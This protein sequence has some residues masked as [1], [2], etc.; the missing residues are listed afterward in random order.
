MVT[1]E[2]DNMTNPFDG[3]RPTIILGAG[4]AGLTA[5]WELVEQGRPTMVVDLEDAPGG[6]C[7]TH[8]KD[9]YRFDLGGHRFISRD[10]SLTDM[11]AGL[12]GDDLLQASRQSMILLGGKR[13]RYPL[14]PLNMLQNLDPV[15]G[16]RGVLDYLKQRAWGETPAPGAEVSFRN[17]TEA[18]YGRTFYD[19]FFGPYTEKLWG[20]PAHTLSGDW[21]SQRISLLNLTDV[22]LRLLKVRGGSTRTYARKYHYPRKGIGQIFAAMTD[23]LRRRGA[24]VRLGTRVTGLELK[25]GEVARVELDGPL[26]SYSV[27]PEQVISTLPLPDLARMLR[28]DSPAVV[29]AADR[30]RFRAVRF[31]DMMLDRPDLSPNTWMYVPDPRCVFTRIQE[32]KRRSPES[33]PPGKTSVMLEIPCDV[34]DEIWS[35]TDADLMDRCLGE[36]KMLGFDV[37]RHVRGCMSQRI[38]HGSV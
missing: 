17:W 4:A 29:D 23:E 34:G 12:L 32:P 31:L 6:L 10:P 33:A 15:V 3:A 13:Y 21:A 30:L 35:Q 38:T 18:R 11:V 19:L 1:E 5:A 25:R 2:K 9:G 36:L 22:A 28:P 14:E 8:E 20:I 24:V 37:A 16:L 26:G 27:A 7:R